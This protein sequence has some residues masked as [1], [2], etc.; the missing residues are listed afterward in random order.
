MRADLE[1][2]IVGRGRPLL[3]LHSLLSDKSSFHPLVERLA[4]RR[5]LI[6]VNMPGFGRSPRGPTGVEA[7][8]DAV[9][10][11]FDDL[12]LPPGTDI[13]GNGLGGFVALALAVRHG[14]RFDR[15]VLIGG[16]AAFPE[17]GRASF[18]MLADK[19]EREGMDAL[20]RAA[21]ERMFPPDFIA[22]EPAAVAV[23]E[24]AFKR[25][26]P[27]VFAASARALAEL[28]FASRLARIDN[29]VLV[30][31]GEKDQATPPALARELAARLGNGRA[32]EMPGLGHVPHV[33]AADRFVAAISD[34]LDL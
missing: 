34:F 21:A 33:Q 20:A 17:A 12:S 27:S 32:V 22:A 29:P 11:I 3:C 13:V 4:G 1:T 28:D 14:A 10:T 5:R 24:A 8:A 19:A 26:P 15:A 7:Y 25:I 2:E 9:A 6:L 18:R 30:V 16:A 23:A 31:V